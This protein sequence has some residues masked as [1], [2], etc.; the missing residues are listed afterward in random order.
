MEKLY[1]LIS[2]PDTFKDKFQ[3]FLKN[4][5]TLNEDNPVNI[6]GVYINEY[7]AIPK[8]PKHKKEG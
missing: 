3:G 7:V 4:I 2:I 1:F 8:I 6:E 5:N